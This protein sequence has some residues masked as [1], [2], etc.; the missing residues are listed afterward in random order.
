M[1]KIIICL[2]AFVVAF[3]VIG[4]GV[5]EQ[6]DSEKI[7]ETEALIAEIGE[8]NGKN[9]KLIIKAEEAYNA[10]SED[11]KS[12]ID[13]YN[14]LLSARE[15]YDKMPVI[16]D[17]KGI[18]VND[19]KSVLS[20]M[21]LIPS[22]EY[23]Y[24]NTMDKDLVIGTKPSIGTKVESNSKVTIQ[25]SKGP[26]RIDSVS[27]YMHWDYVGRAKDEWQFYDPYIEDEVLHLHCTEVIYGTSFEWKDRNNSGYAAGSASINDTFDKTVPVKLYYSDQKVAA[28]KAQ[29]FKLEV[30]LSDL[31]VDT[32]TDMYFK[33]A[34][35][36]GGREKELTFN[37]AINW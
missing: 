21:G 36:V 25:I 5:Q 35:I 14:V 22:L 28:G 7:A 23:I 24:S 12:L 16:P 17:I 18:D 15:T 10:L 31:N 8:I 2:L 6:V 1:K 19:A 27:S 11:E 20:S 33:V 26:S 29:D 9:E 13:N 37:I 3:G 4:C 34:I 32:P 30:P